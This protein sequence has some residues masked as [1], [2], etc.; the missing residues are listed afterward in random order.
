MRRRLMLATLL[1]ALFALGWWVGRGSGGPLYS[2]LDLFIEVL[3]K[4]ED[5]YVDPIDPTRAVEGAL[6]GMLRDLDPYSQYLDQ[7]S[8]ASLQ[9]VT[10][11]KFSGIGVV[12]GVRDNYPTVISPIEGSP[13]WQAGLR[14]G[15][16]IVKIDG[17]PSAGL[18]I[19]EARDR[20]VGPEGSQVKLL[21]RTDDVEREVVL[22]RREIVTRSVP[23]AFVTEDRVGYLR[24][25]NFSEKSGAEVRQAM[26]RL[27]R[28][29]AKSLIVDLRANPG[30]LL[31]QAVD[32]AEQF[33][34]KG[35]LVV[36]TKGRVRAQNN[37]YYASEAASDL[38]WP[39]VVLIDAGS[40]SASEIVAGALQDRDRALVIGNTSFGKGSVQSVYPLKGRTAALKLT[41]ALYYTPSGRSIHRA[42]R[43]SNPHGDD[44]ADGEEPS[45]PA[46]GG[47]DTTAR[48]AYLTVS[49]RRV[50][51]GGGIT[52]D[53]LVER[54]TLPP[55]AQRVEERSLAFRFANRWVS[56]N[57]G[58]HP[59]AGALWPEF[60]A[61]LASENVTTDA[62]ELAAQRA[63]IQRALERELARRVRGDS[64]AVR[65]ALADDPAFRRALEV[66]GRARKPADVFVAAAAPAPAPARGEQAADRRRAPVGAG[67]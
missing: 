44:F 40:A 9:S 66:L 7:K 20:I 53:V 3:H 34:P 33:L 47:A 37:R 14:S 45:Q 50:L 67:R 4:I 55:I 63:P 38:E 6:K 23:Y 18:G 15:D 54:D 32:V 49:G 51:G 24:L 17:Q 42:V 16:V 19:E 61:Y 60:A 25:A 62:A 39:M 29:G 48:P 2:N 59:A 27:K 5:N 43:D 57:P 22:T 13:A 31:D 35:T 28:Q 10:E 56:R 58:A 46:P 64:A 12:M 21:V 11:G 1:V 41:T 8:Y 52:P 36:Y 26:A 30:G 65:V